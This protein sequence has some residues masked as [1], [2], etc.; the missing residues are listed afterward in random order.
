MSDGYLIAGAAAIAVVAVSAVIFH[1]SRASIDLG[2]LTDP[3]ERASRAQLYVIVYARTVTAA[4]LGL[5][6]WM[7]LW[8]VT[9]GGI[10]GLWVVPVL[11]AVVLACY[12]L[13]KRT[14]R[15]YARWFLGV[16]A[17]MHTEASPKIPGAADS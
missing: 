17:S 11:A 14:G 3:Y 10:G 12:P 1:S 15:M 16:D 13:A 7:G 4:T 9:T 6:A 8:L 2:R 5:I